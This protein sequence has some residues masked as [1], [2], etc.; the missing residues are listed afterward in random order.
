[1]SRYHGYYKTFDVYVHIV[2]SLYHSY[3]KIHEVYVPNDVM[4]PA[5]F[6]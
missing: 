2:K 3:S 1:M 6:L 5:L 4:I